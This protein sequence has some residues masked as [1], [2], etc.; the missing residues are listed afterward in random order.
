[1]A[2]VTLDDGKQRTRIVSLHASA[3][4][5]PLPFANGRPQQLALQERFRIG[6]IDVQV[7]STPIERGDG[8]LLVEPLQR[9]ADWWLDLRFNGRQ[10]TPPWALSLPLS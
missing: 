6:G 7:A 10:Q 3:L 8:F 2:E 1:V 4:H 9:G 5:A